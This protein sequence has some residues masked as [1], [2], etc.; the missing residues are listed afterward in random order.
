MIKINLIKKCGQKRNI[1]YLCKVSKSL[2]KGILSRFQTLFRQVM[3]N[4]LNPIY[5]NI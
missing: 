4:K 2:E 3:S 5:K 1:S